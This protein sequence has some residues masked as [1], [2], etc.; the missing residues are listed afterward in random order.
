MASHPEEAYSL[1][2]T[3]LQETKKARALALERQRD[4]ELE[5]KKFDDMSL[6]VSIPSPK[7]MV[8]STSKSKSHKAADVTLTTAG[9]TFLDDEMFQSIV[10]EKGCTTIS[11]PDHFPD[12]FSEVTREEALSDVLSSLREEKVDNY[13]LHSLPQTLSQ[14]TECQSKILECQSKHYN[15]TVDGQIKS[16]CNQKRI[17][18]LLENQLAT[19]D[20][21]V[22]LS[23]ALMEE[24]VEAEVARRLAKKEKT[25]ANNRESKATTFRPSM[26]SSSNSTKCVAA[27]NSTPFRDTTNIR[28][29]R[30]NKLTNPKGPGTY[31]KWEEKKSAAR[32][33]KE[34]SRR[35][36][37][38]GR[39]LPWE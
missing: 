32:A 29:T 10:A 17:I 5:D 35:S 12:E 9:L 36:Q 8:E 27:N 34:E 14:V 11:I 39:K 33:R 25:K 16:E 7:S 3:R 15:Q 6:L 4:F 2:E 38:P 22:L 21:L 37:A 30:P 1:P 28:L 20:T 23:E 18:N 13:I 26:R 19:Q 24:K 31:Q